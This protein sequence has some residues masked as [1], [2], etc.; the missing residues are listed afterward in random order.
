MLAV[1]VIG[2]PGAGKTTVLTALQNLLADD[3]IRHAAIELEALAWAHPAISDEQS[4]RHLAALSEM[5]GAARY[6]LIICG[7]TVT[8]DAFMTSLV[9]ALAADARLI[10]RLDAPVRTLRQRITQREPP[11]WSGL[12]H[13][14]RATERIVVQSRRLTEVDATFSTDEASPRAIAAEIRGLSPGLRT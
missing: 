10:V 7:A 14:L 12:P 9:A 11:G 8:S 2:P 3:G 13:L 4:F 6:D 5:Y 1:V